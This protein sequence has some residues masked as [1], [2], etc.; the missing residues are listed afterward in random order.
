MKVERLQRCAAICSRRLLFPN[1]CRTPL[2]SD[3][4]LSVIKR[5]LGRKK[6][7]RYNLSTTGVQKLFSFH[8]ESFFDKI[9]VLA[10]FA[11]TTSTMYLL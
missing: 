9:C 11:I 5:E 6:H 1:V 10:F 3:E 2:V 8:G 7:H 4:L